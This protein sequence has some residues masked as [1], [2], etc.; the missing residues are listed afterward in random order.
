MNTYSKTARL[1]G[2][3]YLIVIVTGFF[4]LMYVPSKLIVWENPALTFQYM[5]SSAQLFRLSI[6][7]SIVCYIAF[8]FLPSFSIISTVEGG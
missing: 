1:A 6:A 4:S 2:F 3:F 8:T 7:S 5:S